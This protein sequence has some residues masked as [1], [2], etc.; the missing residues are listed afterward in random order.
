[1]VELPN[2]F[3]IRSTEKHMYAICLDPKDRFFGWKM[4]EH[5]D[6]KWVSVGALTKEEIIRAKALPSLAGFIDE[7]DKL[8]VELS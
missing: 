8:L 2:E 1:M 5:P 4:L 7:L 6:K 3:W